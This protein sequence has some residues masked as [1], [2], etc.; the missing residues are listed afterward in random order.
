MF[1]L[2]ILRLFL[3]GVRVWDGEMDRE[4]VGKV[5]D[6]VGIVLRRLVGKRYEF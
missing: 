3:N 5:I 1:F 6:K 2:G 4:I